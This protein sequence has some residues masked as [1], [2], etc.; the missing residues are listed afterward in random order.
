MRTTSP[1]ARLPACPS[2]PHR[3]ESLLRAVV[4]WVV[5]VFALCC[6]TRVAAQL[7]QVVPS[8]GG[9]II[10]DVLIEGRSGVDPQLLQANL[11]TRPG[12]PLDQ[13]LIDADI[14]WMHDSYGII[15]EGVFIDPGPVVRFQLQR[16]LQYAWVRLEGNDRFGDKTLLGTARLREGQGATPDQV[17][18]AR[19]LITDHYLK[20]G[21]AFVE[22]DTLAAV[23]EGGRRGVRILV[24]EG[25]EVNVNTLTVE[26]LST[27]S[28]GDAKGILASK[29]GFWAWLVGKDFVKTN[30]ER[31]VVVLENFVRGEG[32]LDAEVAVAPHA[33]SSDREDVD[34]KLV[35]DERD[36]YRVGAITLRGN[37]ILDR[38]V[39]LKEAA[40]EEGGWYRQP[41][42]SRVVR[43]I[44]REYGELG[45]LDVSVRVEEFFDLDN[46]VVDVEFV[47]D[48]GVK[49]KIRD[50]II[51][52]NTNT[53]DG[54]V[55]RYLTIY[56]GD[57]VKLSELRYSEDA[58]IA[59]GYFS[60]LSGTPKVRVSHEPTNDPEY[61]DVVV[62]IDDGSS[63]IF[64]FVVGAASD[65]GIFG[66][67]TLDKRNFDISRP[68][69]S[70]GSFFPEFFGAGKAYHGGGQRLF[71]ELVPGTETT[72]FNIVFSE[73]WLDESKENPWGLTV[74][75]YKRNR[76]FREY[77]RNT[78]G[79]GVFFDHRFSRESS[80][81]IGPRLENLTIDNVDDRRRDAITGE[82][83]AFA[84]D[85]GTYD[86]R[87]M[88]GSWRYSKVDSLYEP[89]D[90]Y[91]TRLRS[92]FVGG[93]L[94]GDVDVYNVTLGNELF[95]PMGE[96]D[97]GHMRVF[98]PRM[99]VGVV[100]GHSGDDPPFFE[101]LFVGGASGSFPVRGF[102]FQGIG[103]HEEMVTS[104]QIPG[105]GAKL[106]KH[107]GEPVGGQLAL[108]GSLEAVFPLV[109]EYNPYRDRDDILVKGVIFSDFG[110]LRE[111]IE[112]NE[113]FDEL[114]VS[115]GAGVRLRLPALGGITLVLDYAITLREEDVDDTRPFSFELS[116]RF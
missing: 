114:R 78:D 94:G 112:V 109:A 86:R 22:L 62:D 113:L 115:L 19:S 44:R 56:P 28:E 116:R 69:S 17:A 93:V 40:L 91:I 52:G 6:A 10:A 50:I 64:S 96:N 2:E 34:L 60:D 42:L 87:A 77:D 97:E 46:P 89:T 95:V 70:F 51:R 24:F 92:Q 100:D 38:D 65:S 66:G 37:Q 71:I 14:R 16:I 67:I 43:Q 111:D 59:L 85:E 98:H 47:I 68:S 36:R 15:V 82:Q 1:R 18:K 107:S 11:R 110:N 108:A 103:P 75:L 58:L 21:H 31:D 45:Y 54:V 25:P 83:T 29:R 90:G 5:V 88:E 106:S 35:V 48:E 55:R 27:I 57:D 26:G 74:E 81:S 102:D 23:D 53:R 61:V 49:K 32:F 3:G 76:Y 30:L 80:I 105:G 63:G 9:E 84:R 101:N 73:P 8:T 99:T 13:A 20:R 7:Q 4:P 39:L 12:R 41:D 79:V 72:N 33:W 104:N